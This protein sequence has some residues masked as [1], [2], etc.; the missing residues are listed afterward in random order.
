MFV[1]SES[2]H[3]NDGLNV[4]N[5]RRSVCSADCDGCASCQG[6]RAELREGVYRNKRKSARSNPVRNKNKRE[7]KSRYFMVTIWDM[8]V[9]MQRRIMA[10]EHNDKVV[11][12]VCQEELSPTTKRRHYQGYIVLSDRYR[13]S[14]V[15]ALLEGNP[16]T[17]CKFS[18]GNHAECFKYCTKEDTRV[19]GGFS[20]VKGIFEPKKPGK[21]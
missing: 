8:S 9:E 4:E 11:K 17:D 5:I 13:S 2:L 16:P 20:F 14:W 15:Q 7:K 6:V 3:S 19:K 21:R 1:S 10:F 18:D 12:F